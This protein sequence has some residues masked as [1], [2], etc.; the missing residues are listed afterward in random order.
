MV[1]PLQKFVCLFLAATMLAGLFASPAIQHTHTDAENSHTHVKHD[2]HDEHTHNH[3]HD[4]SSSDKEDSVLS[5]MSHLHFN[6]LGFDFTLPKR[7]Y[8]SENGEQTDETIVFISANSTEATLLSHFSTFIK[9]LTFNNISG[10]F[11]AITANASTALYSGYAESH[12][13]LCDTA[14]GERSGVLLT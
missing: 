4:D 1:I 5:A 8:D 9:P 13:F 2:E 12:Y 6:W 11:T 3:S 7:P 10:S 14:R